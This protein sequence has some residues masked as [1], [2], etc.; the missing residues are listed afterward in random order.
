MSVW[1][2][3]V[4]IPKTIG[5]EY[6][7]TDRGVPV[8]ALGHMTCAF[9]NE[10]RFSFSSKGIEEGSESQIWREAYMRCY[11]TLHPDNTH[12]GLIR[13]NDTMD[14][15]DRRLVYLAA[16]ALSGYTEGMPRTALK[17]AAEAREKFGELRTTVTKP[18]NKKNNP[19]H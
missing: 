2:A 3:E 10:P 17:L 11:Q 4:P 7:A 9:H 15:R 6:F 16:W 19:A 8:C 14:A 13:A 18:R 12:R 5:T 1:P